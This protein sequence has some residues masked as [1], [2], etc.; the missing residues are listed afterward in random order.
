ML[1]FPQ[2][3]LRNWLWFLDLYHFIKALWPLYNVGSSFQ[4]HRCD[5]YS[6]C[7]ENK[8][9]GE[10][11]VCAKDGKLFVMPGTESNTAENLEN[12]VWTE[13]CSY[14]SILYDACLTSFT[15][16]LPNW[17][18][19]KYAFYR[20]KVETLVLW[21][22]LYPYVLHMYICTTRSFSQFLCNKIGELLFF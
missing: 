22:F 7:N 8:T 5:K 4:L 19:R 10:F 15:L 12:D 17:S 16:M 1:A 21:T 11:N 20:K 9:W 13:K 14:K 2:R 3:F 6:S 18:K